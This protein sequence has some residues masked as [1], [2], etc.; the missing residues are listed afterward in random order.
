M[1]RLLTDLKG[2]AAAFALADLTDFLLADRLS[3]EEAPTLATAAED[4]MAL[5]LLFHL[6][7]TY[8]I[9]QLSEPV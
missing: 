2:R 1:A 4:A 3:P 8:S 9:T 7:G 6:R 5:D